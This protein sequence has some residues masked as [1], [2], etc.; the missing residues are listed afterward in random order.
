MNVLEVL[1][2]PVLLF[3]WEYG[4]VFRRGKI[5]KWILVFGELDIFTFQLVETFSFLI[6]FTFGLDYLEDLQKNLD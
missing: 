2:M 6:C 5:G 4:A 3:L 1:K